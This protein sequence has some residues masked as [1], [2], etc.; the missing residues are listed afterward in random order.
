MTFMPMMSVGKILTF[1]HHHSY[2]IQP[3]ELVLG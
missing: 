3:K 1:I 2:H